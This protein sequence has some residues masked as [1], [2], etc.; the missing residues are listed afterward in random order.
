MVSTPSDRNAVAYPEVAMRH[1]VQGRAQQGARGEHGGA[2]GPEVLA[3]TRPV[4]V[5]TM[6]T[7]DLA[8][9][10]GEFNHRFPIYP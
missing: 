1:P 7:V 4:P 9:K 6:K 5:R 10:N 2:V 8:I 3:V